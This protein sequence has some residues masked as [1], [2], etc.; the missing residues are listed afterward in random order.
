M[1]LPS[2]TPSDFY[3]SLIA[4]TDTGTDPDLLM[5]AEDYL[6]PMSLTAN[7]LTYQSQD[8]FFPS[9]SGT[10]LWFR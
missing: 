9:V 5:D 6:Q 2:P 7:N 3:K 1:A 10:S 4:D 8:G